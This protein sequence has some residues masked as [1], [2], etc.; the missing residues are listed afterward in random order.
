L[1]DIEVVASEA[2]HQEATGGSPRN[3][4]AFSKVAAKKVK[5]IPR[6]EE[7]CYGRL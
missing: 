6:A 1:D 5:Q 2:Y 4:S 7:N 3:Q